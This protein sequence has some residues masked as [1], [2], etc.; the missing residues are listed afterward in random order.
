MFFKKNTFKI[1]IFVLLLTLFF[2]IGFI[3]YL[4]EARVNNDWPFNAKIGKYFPNIIKKIVWDI[5]SNENSIVESF[6]YDLSLNKYKIPSVNSVE[7]GGS[8]ELINNNQVLLLLNNGEIFIFD[9]KKLDYTKIEYDYIQK[10]FVSIRDILLVNKNQK[11]KYLVLL[12]VSEKKEGCMQL[13]LLKFNLNFDTDLNFVSFE[14]SETIWNSEIKCNNPAINTFGSRVIYL[15]DYYYL[16]MGYVKVTGNNDGINDDSQNLKSMFG[17]ILKISQDGTFDIFS[18]G[19]RNPQGLFFSKNK[20]LIF[21]TEH[22]PSGGDEINLIKRNNNYGWPCSTYG[23]LYDFKKDELSKYWP[24]DI[25]NCN[26]DFTEPLYSWTPSIAISQGL[27]YFGDEFSIFN[28]D[29]LVGSLKAQSIF[30]IRLDKNNIIRN[31]EKIFINE[32]IRDLILLDSGKILILS[33]SGNL[34][35]LE[36]K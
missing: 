8:I 11:D 36:K 33:D 14:N 22:G 16:T 31:I 4:R 15:E 17:K 10:N 1:I 12:G 5:S 35:I 3:I 30:R 29:L 2:I 24:D 9:I 26:R 6:F 7:H 32:R 23:I 34:L 28:N 27:E 19:H 25:K 21:S 20:N 13:E 18:S